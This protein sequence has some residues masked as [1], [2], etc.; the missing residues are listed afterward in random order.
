MQTYSRAPESGPRT[1]PRSTCARGTHNTLSIAPRIHGRGRSRYHILQAVVLPR[2]VPGLGLCWDEVG[3]GD[4]SFPGSACA[5][6]DT[7]ASSSMGEMGALLR[8]GA[9]PALSVHRRSPAPSI[10]RARSFCASAF[11]AA[12]GGGL[13]SCGF[14]PAHAWGKNKAEA[15]KLQLLNLHGGRPSP[16]ACASPATT[17]PGVLASLEGAA[18][19]RDGVRGGLPRVGGQEAGPGHRAPNDAIVRVTRGHLRLGPASVA[20]VGGWPVPTAGPKSAT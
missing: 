3:H 7:C 18:H 4:G 17:W 19:A 13:V 20:W 5:G 15:L 1:S 2:A 11:A 12:S 8:A 16:S 10:R 6:A 14:G 9:G